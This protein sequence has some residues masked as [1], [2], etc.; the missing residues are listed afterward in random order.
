MKRTYVP[1]SG[2]LNAMLAGVGEQPGIQ[3]IQYRPPKPFVGPAGK[4]LDELLIMTKIP[5]Q[6]VYLTNVIKDL[7]APLRHYINIDKYGRSTISKEGYQYI[8]ELGE[9]L[10]KLKLNVVVAFGNVPLLALCNRLGITKWRGSVLESTLVPGLKVV[11]TFH[12]ATLIPHAGSQ[13]NYLNKPLIIEDLMRAKYESEFKEIRRTGR[14]VSIKPSF[15]QSSQ[16][17][18]HCYEEGLRGRTIDLDIEV[19]NGEVDCIAF[20][21]SPTDSISIPFR[22]RNGDYFTVEQ[23]YEIMLLVGQIIS[24]ERIA[25]RGAYFIF[26]TQFLFHKYGIIPRGELHCTQIAQKISYP[27]FPAGL[28]FVTTMHTDIP[29]YKQDG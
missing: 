9:E 29:Y 23:E 17:L 7:D 28:D 5:R 24:D 26:D 18:T 14:N 13:P 27:D 2:N 4:Q 8:H 3:E 15:S 25:K 10:S 21:W 16:V 20:S 19:I 12:P 11:P 1:P 22:D 6:E